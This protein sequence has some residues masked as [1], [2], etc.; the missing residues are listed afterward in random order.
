MG[1]LRLWRGDVELDAGPTQQRCLLA[2]LLARAGRPTSMPALVELLWEQE[3]PPS[4]VNAIHKYVG[5]LRRLLEPGLPPRAPGSYLLRHGDGYRFVADQDTLD[6]VGFRQSV[7]AGKDALDRG[8]AD[9]ALRH[10]VT[11]LKHCQGPA[12]EALG[13]SPGAAAVFARIDS[14]FFEAVVAATQ[15]AVPLGQPALVLAALRLAAAMSPLHEPVHASLMTALAAAGQQAEALA[16]FQSI[17][18]RLAEE[19]GIDPGPGVQASYQRVLTQAVRPAPLTS[20]ASST[21]LTT[22]TTFA[23]S[24]PSTLSSPFA[25]SD[26]SDP[27][28]PSAPP[29][30]AGGP[31]PARPAQLP[32]DVPAFVGRDTELAA[33]RGLV[34]EHRETD[35]L[36]P[37]VVAMHGMAGVGKSALATHFAHQAVGEFPD[38]QL[39]LDLQQ[40]LGAEG[41]VSAGDALC[42]LLYAL[43]VSVP[44]MPGAFDARVGAYR[45]LTAGKRFLVLL[46]NARDAAAVRPLLP[47]SARSLVLVTSRRPLVGLAALDGAYLMRV[48]V[49]SLPAARKLLDRRLGELSAR[50]TDRVDPQVAD[51][52]IES[53]GRLPL[54]LVSLAA[55]MAA[56]P[57]LSLV[58]LAADLGDG[59]G[60]LKAFPRGGEAGDLRS[61]FAWSY[62]QLSPGA[63]RLFRLLWAPLPAAAPAQAWASLAGQDLART[64]SELDELTDAALVDEG[65]DGR[66]SAH[67]LVRAY[68]EE[69][70]Q[71]ADGDPDR[72]AAVSRLLEHYLHS[73][74]HAQV[75]LQP[76]RTAIPPSPPRSPVLPERPSGYDEAIAWFAGQ[77]EMLKDAVRLAADERYGVAGWQLALSMQQYLQWSGRF[78][79]WEEVM[80]SAGQAARQQGDPV[81]EAHT[82]RSLAGA[83]WSLGA[84][85]EALGLL[86]SALR[87]YERLDMRLEQA[88]VHSNVHRVYDSLGRHGQALAHAEQAIAL[89][90]E[91]GHRRGEAFGFMARGKSLSRLGQLEESALL[92]GQA[93]E[94]N[95]EIGPRH[96]EG[97]TRIVIAA[98]LLK[99]GRTE[100]A[101]DQLVMSADI[102]REVGDRPNEFAAQRHLTRALTDLGDTAG[103]IRALRRTRA[104]LATFQGGGPGIMHAACARL[105]AR[106]PPDDDLLSGV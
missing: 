60:W 96:E 89:Y 102:S 90:R 64:R 51:E 40:H 42:S 66:F 53:C 105:A 18:T 74:Y 7:A 13:D 100:R 27:S 54:A 81:G 104:V 9:E 45:T 106:L 12:G 62:R 38:G 58:A 35:R 37:L 65:G 101:V 82:L 83:R 46:D 44:D 88:L 97:E 39:Y 78:Q 72:Q 56:R 48:E 14:E 11:A 67:V 95:Q 24:S 73:S 85:Q 75:M 30:R 93:I 59:P 49:P 28:I 63:A 2:L 33:L 71:C 21:P 29:V 79:D 16:V 68:A 92:L 41:R 86:R 3:A 99:D 91:L 22:Y 31:P 57:G 43:G 25:P 4:A 19:L 36:S 50:C 69:L 52:I 23:L 80:R 8:R 87:V 10:Y 84:S 5:R 47:S 34:A 1:P 20:P 94:A 103:A 6:L 76:N 70:G 17:R 77:R 26:P 15:I 98:N 61:A 55:R 32:P